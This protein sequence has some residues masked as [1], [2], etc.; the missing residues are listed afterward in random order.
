M[1][2]YETFP[3][4]IRTLIEIHK[5]P[6][7]TYP[8]LETT[9]DIVRQRRGYFGEYML[10]ASVIVERD[11]RVVM[12]QQRPV[13]YAEPGVWFFPGGGVGQDEAIADAA[14]REVK[15]ETGLDVEL[16]EPLGV[17]KSGR[18][19]PHEGTIDSFLIIFAA[20]VVGG[21]LEPQDKE[22]VAE[23]RLAT[24][25]DIEEFIT[26]DAFF[27][28]NPHMRALAIEC[29]RRWAARRRPPAANDPPL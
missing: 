5:P 14:V 19:A 4:R 1:P 15:E 16:L 23:A 8:Y 26:A 12:I 29:F 2:D 3:L 20:R 6:V 27:G 21:R 22:E 7:H 28:K 18:Q 11:G 24:I 10:F 9:D 17:L 25:E 13:P